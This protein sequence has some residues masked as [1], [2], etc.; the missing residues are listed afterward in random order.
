MYPG[1]VLIF[2]R[3][4]IFKEISRL[5]TAFQEVPKYWT[6]FIGGILV[7]EKLLFDRYSGKDCFLIP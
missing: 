4:F 1:F 6:A 5:R 2:K 3:Y 7:L